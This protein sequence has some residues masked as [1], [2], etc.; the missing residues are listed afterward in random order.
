[1]PVGRG[2]RKE[3]AN[4]SDRPLRPIE[5][6]IAAPFLSR[7]KKDVA[8]ILRVFS[9]DLA[10][11]LNPSWTA[12]S[13]TGIENSHLS[14]APRP[15]WRRQSHTPQE[16]TAARSPSPLAYYRR[17]LDKAPPLLLVAAGGEPPHTAAVRR[18]AAENHDAASID[19]IAGCW[20]ANIITWTRP[21][22]QGAVC[23]ASASKTVDA[24]RRVVE[25]LKFGHG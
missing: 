24:T 3:W 1:M 2:L 25:G 22:R 16:E 8:T 9:S 13:Q 23:E 12:A 10:G 17:P 20:V 15:H 18:Y 7:S 21:S 6:Q 5:Q 4:K 14:T 11:L 19:G